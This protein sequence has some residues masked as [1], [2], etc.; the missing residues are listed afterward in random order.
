MTVL[1]WRMVVDEFRPHIV[2]FYSLSNC[3]ETYWEPLSV[4]R[5]R[6]EQSGFLEA[7][8]SVNVAIAPS[9]IALGSN[10]YPTHSRVNAKDVE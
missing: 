7:K 8:A 4:L 5:V 2:C 3:N 10:A 6:F 1:L 9:V